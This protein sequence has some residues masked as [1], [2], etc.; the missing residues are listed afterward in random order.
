MSEMAEGEW[1]FVYWKDD[2][3]LFGGYV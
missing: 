2:I 3:I 1:R